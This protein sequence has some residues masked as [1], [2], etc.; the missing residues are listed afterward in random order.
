MATEDPAGQP[1]DPLEALR[2]L[3]RELGLP[4]DPDISDA[5]VRADLFKTMMNR[6]RP[7]P[8]V[9]DET[10]VWETARQTARHVVSSLGPD[11]SGSSRAAR[12]VSDAVH[13]AELW[14]SEATVLAPVPLTPVVWSRAE[15]IEATLP[16]W[17]SMIEPIIGT[18]ATAVAEATGSRVDLPESDEMAGLQSMIRPIMSRVISAMFG[19]H[20]GEGL[21]W[22]ATATMTGT[23]LGLPLIQ[24]PHVV[25]LSTNLSAIQQQ[26][27]LEEEGL[28]MYCSLREA[29]RQ[30]LFRE[31]GWIVPQVSALVQHYA[32]EMRV[33]PDAIASAMESA[34]PDHLSAETVAAFQTDFS[35][36]LFSPDQS[37][38][39]RDILKRLSTLLALIEGWV[40][41]V[42]GIVSRRWLPD[43]AAVS[44]SL[45]RD[46]ATSKVSQRIVTPLIGLSAT[47]K[48][49]RQAAGFWAAVRDARGIEGRD[50]VWRHPEAMPQAED[51]GDP[52]GYLA[53]SAQTSDPWDDELRRFLDG[54]PATGLPD[55]DGEPK[56]GPISEDDGDHGAGEPPT[57]VG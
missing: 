57:G 11:P 50:D 28:L 40:D 36:I 30:R 56:P 7:A 53:Q 8:G 38:E 42:T 51:L 12:H 33:D 10:V 29:A 54:D 5:E 49:I 24:T 3:F 26:A 27:E 55:G 4:E 15:W 14:L 9:S 2:K 22:A 47:P 37:D 45:R 39:Q 21:G 1:P 48:A 35:S 43:W 44:E 20:V 52:A 25:I 34:V 6:F 13:L 17:K 46:R 16:A 19:A 31:V 23:D 32:R 41:D 18:L